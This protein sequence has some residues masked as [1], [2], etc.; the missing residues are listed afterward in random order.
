MAKE[1]L[2]PQEVADLLHLSVYSVKKLAREGV[3]PGK[4]VGRQ[5]RFS[6]RAV[7][8]WLEEERLTE[9]EMARVREGEAQIARGEYVTL[10]EL[11]EELRQ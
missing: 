9:E 1:V 2:T 5:W 10:G 8:E 3:L 6:H 4:R 11:E 7:L